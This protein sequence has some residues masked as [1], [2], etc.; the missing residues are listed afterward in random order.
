MK[1][2]IFQK[3]LLFIC[4]FICLALTTYGI[5]NTRILPNKIAKVN[6]LPIT[7]KIIVVD[8]RSSGSLT[9]VLSDLMGL[10]NKQ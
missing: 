5:M 4:F 1:L 2:T 9:K 10:R 7:N 6:A 8:S 3:R